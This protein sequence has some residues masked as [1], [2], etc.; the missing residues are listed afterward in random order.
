MLLISERDPSF[1]VNEFCWTYDPREPSPF[2]PFDL[3]EDQAKALLWLKDLY[4]R[5]KDGIF[6][7]SRD[8]GATW[9][10][11]AFAVWAWLFK[12]GSAIGFGSRKLEL[13]DKIGDP[14]SIFDKIRFI[15]RN[16]PGWL[17]Q[18]KAPGF[19]FKTHD[20]FC[21]IINPA[22]GSSITGEGGD[23]IGR[24]GRTSIYFV[25]EA[26]FLPRPLLVDQA[27]TANSRCKILVSTPRGA[28]NPFAVKR[29]SQK[30]PVYTLH[31]KS[32]PRKTAWLIV[33]LDWE[34]LID[35]DGELEL[36]QEGVDFI[37]YGIGR[38]PEPPAGHRVIYPWYEELCLKE[39]PITVAQEYDID[40]SASLEGV[41]IP[42]RWLRACVGLSLPDGLS[43]AGFDVAAG[44]AENV[45]LMRKGP[46]VS[47]ITRWR[48]E[49]P[50]AAAFRV[51]RM[52][53]ADQIER[54]F[55]DAIGVGAGVGGAMKLVRRALTF[56]WTAVNVG[57]PPTETRW[58]DKMKSKEK[59]ANLKA[60]LWWRVRAR[61][62]RTYQ[63]VM[64]GVN[65]PKEDLLSLPPGP[66]TEALISQLSGVRYFETETG[67]IIVESKKELARRGVSSPDIAEALILSFMP[68]SSRSSTRSGSSITAKVRPSP[69][70]AS[71]RTALPSPIQP[72]MKPVARRRRG[73]SA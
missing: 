32:D 1:F 10:T 37:D 17:L 33:P 29:L 14:K 2:I 73:M 58:P 18:A 69:K 52:A 64:L 22:N 39:D 36:G 24:G 53:E 67:K 31:W 46:N 3:Y 47:T 43:V 55:Y 4:E 60:E 70:G 56:V 63:F 28:N 7:K 34:G 40:Y 66:D 42:A 65:H 13:V 11:A 19:N 6:E 59:F 72:T 68:L 50:T 71:V 16:L 20:N 5:G 21:K 49:D 54:L 44:G 51:V 8:M 25:D 41:I 35:S 61:A 48:E 62:E 23:E 45:Y 12:P 27:L 26:A 15:I 57:V 38:P 9:L 30:F